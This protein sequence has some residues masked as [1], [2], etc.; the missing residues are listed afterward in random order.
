ME[1]IE[2]LPKNECSELMGWCKNQG[3]EEEI[4]TGKKT[5]RTKK[6]WGFE[7]EFYF[8]RSHVFDRDPIESDPYLASL[9]DK[10]RPGS[11]S[12][13]LYRY[14]IGGEIGEHLDKQCFDPMVTLI[15]LVDNLPN[16]FG[17][18]PTTKF[19]WDR[20]NYEL[21]NGEVVTFNSRVLHSV[22]K[23]KSARYS[24]QFRNI[25]K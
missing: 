13:L 5:C 22:P 12:I 4:F 25:A 11:D 24:L 8:N 6:W 3:L 1:T 7:A 20:S 23:L 15:N 10:Y 18:Y 21:K 9:R 14:E 19:R 2:I 17:E 16:L